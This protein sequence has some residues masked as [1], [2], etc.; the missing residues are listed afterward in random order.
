MKF[1]FLILILLLIP[2]VR[3]HASELIT[4]DCNKENKEYIC[5]FKGNFDYEISAIDFHYSIPKYA[6]QNSF[7]VLDNWLGETDDFWVSLYSDQNL[8]GEFPIME[9]TISSKKKISNDDITISDVLVYDEYYQEHK[10]DI[11]VKT[12]KKCQSIIVIAIICVIIMVA[13]ILFI[14]RRLIKKG[15]LQ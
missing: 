3:V 12:E 2:L 10:I 1:K 7:K 13:I 9:V 4:V 6:T 11:D 15:D 5:K 8:Q 14:K